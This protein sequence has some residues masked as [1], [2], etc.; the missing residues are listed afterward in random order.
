[1]DSR[2][3]DNLS[4][5]LASSS[6]TRVVGQFVQGL[7]EKALP[8]EMTVGGRIYDLVSLKTGEKSIVDNTREKNAN[9]K[10]DDGDYILKHQQDIPVALR[11]NVIFVF[12]NWCS[13]ESWKN[14]DYCFWQVERWVRCWAWLCHCPP[15]ICVR[16]LCR[17]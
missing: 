4:N 10:K 12:S 14:S 6:N 17:E 15:K 2:P 3:F 9:P 16:L 13:A 1:M 7:G 5:V 8:T 11:G